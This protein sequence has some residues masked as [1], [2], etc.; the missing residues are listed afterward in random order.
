M[1]LRPLIAICSKREKERSSYEYKDPD[2]PKPIKQTKPLFLCFNA[3]ILLYVQAASP[4][5]SE[6][7]L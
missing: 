7:S 1:V 3:T 5:K 6:G 4:S 2:P